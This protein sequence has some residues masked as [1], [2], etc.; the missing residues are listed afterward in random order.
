MK[1]IYLIPLV[2]LSACSE[3]IPNWYGLSCPPPRRYDVA[4]DRLETALHIHT[5]ARRMQTP[6]LEPRPDLLARMYHCLVNESV[7]SDQWNH[8][9]ERCK[10]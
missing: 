4:L 6:N 10:Q 2:L 8:W 1:P 9:E 7:D 5:L 3:E